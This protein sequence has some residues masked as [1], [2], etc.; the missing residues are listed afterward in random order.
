MKDVPVEDFT[1]PTDLQIRFAD[2]L[3]LKIDDWIG[4]SKADMSKH[5]STQKEWSDSFRSIHKES[6]ATGKTSVSLYH[7]YKLILIICIE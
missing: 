4:C 3:G 7:C 2:N 6:P 1:L 5:I